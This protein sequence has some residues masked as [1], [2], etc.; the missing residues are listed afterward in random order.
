M[1]LS[2]SE[3]V[4][5]HRHE[6]LLIGHTARPP[7]RCERCGERNAFWRLRDGDG[8]ERDLCPYCAALET[9]VA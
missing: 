7:S 9:Q 2:T 4:G 5:E 6:I 1:G 3:P 8:H